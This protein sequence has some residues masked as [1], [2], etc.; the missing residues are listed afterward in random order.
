M[1]D[2]EL[3]SGEERISM[4]HFLL[5]KVQVFFSSGLVLKNEELKYDS[6]EW[7]IPLW[8]QLSYNSFGVNLAMSLEMD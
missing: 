3:N 6:L 5:L 2:C 7:V 8:R 1:G 4:W